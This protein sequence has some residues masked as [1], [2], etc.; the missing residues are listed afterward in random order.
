VFQVICPARPIFGTPQTGSPSAPVARSIGN[1]RRAQLAT[2]ENDAAMPAWTT[3]FRAASQMR[4]ATSMWKADLEPE[5]MFSLAREWHTPALASVEAVRQA[6]Y[7]FGKHAWDFLNLYYQACR[8]WSRE[9]GVLRHLP[10]PIFE[11]A[12]ADNVR[13]RRDVLRPAGP[14]IRRVSFRD[15]AATACDALAM[16][17]KSSG[18]TASLIMW[19]SAPPR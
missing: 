8:C 17:G 3:S 5:L 1:W 16:P 12:H 11:R 9:P 18:P 7:R 13:P 10:G 19:L 15:R 6:P 4:A 2:T 14:H